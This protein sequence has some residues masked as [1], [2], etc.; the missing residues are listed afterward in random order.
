VITS[1]YIKGSSHVFIHTSSFGGTDCD[2]DHCLMAAK[3]WKDCWHMNKKHQSL[4]E[5]RYNLKKL[6]EE[7]REQYQVRI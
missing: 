5:E 7:V 1:W 6:N 2:T 4:I 3:L